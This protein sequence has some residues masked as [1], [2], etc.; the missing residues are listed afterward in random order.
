MKRKRSQ[1]AA[2][3]WQ[4]MHWYHR[5]ALT[6]C[7]HSGIDQSCLHRHEG[8]RKPITVFPTQL[9]YILNTLWACMLSPCESSL[10]ILSNCCWRILKADRLHKYIAAT[11]DSVTLEIVLLIASCWILLRGSLLYFYS[12]MLTFNRHIWLHH[13]ISQSH[14][15]LHFCH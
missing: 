10:L 2:K 12:D 6:L 7:G 1:E 8:E 15:I 4:D 13:S 11:D 9:Y 3:L 5:S 14:V